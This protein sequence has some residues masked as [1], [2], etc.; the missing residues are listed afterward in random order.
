[1]TLKNLLLAHKKMCGEPIGFYRQANRFFK[2]SQS[3]FYK[4]KRYL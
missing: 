2:Q 4:R 3:F 1:M